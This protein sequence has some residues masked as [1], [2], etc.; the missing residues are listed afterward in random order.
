MAYLP[1]D[2]TPGT[3]SIEVLL[4]AQTQ[5]TIADPGS[6][7]TWGP[8]TTIAPGFAKPKG[9]ADSKQ[10]M[11]GWTANDGKVFSHLASPETPASQLS[12]VLTDQIFREPSIAL[13]KH[14]REQGHAVTPFE[15]TWAPEG[16]AFGPT[17]CID[18]PLTFGF[19]AWSRSS[20][21]LE[22]NRD[23]WE[24]TGKRWRKRLGDFARDGTPFVAEDGIEVF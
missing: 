1:D 6:I 9:P 4:E 3:V 17:H 14:L 16:F 18:L 2:A 20:M 21:C 7:S 8:T 23:E 10:V 19:E 5:A 11:I 22:K 13:A 24:G 12:N 15:L